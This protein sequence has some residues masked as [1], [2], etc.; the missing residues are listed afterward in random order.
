MDIPDNGLPKYIYIEKHNGKRITF[1]YM[2]SGTGEI[3]YEESWYCP[4][5]EIRQFYRE[6]FSQFTDWLFRNEQPRF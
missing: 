6:D 3:R 4:T 1:Q 5:P 2:K